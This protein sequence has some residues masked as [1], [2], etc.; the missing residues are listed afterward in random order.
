MH[1]I[2]SRGYQV[3][4]VANRNRNRN[5]KQA[6]Q[7]TS[8]ACNAAAASAHPK[9]LT[10]SLKRAF[11]NRQHK[12]PALLVSICPAVLVGFVTLVLVFAGVRFFLRVYLRPSLLNVWVYL[13]SSLCT[14]QMLAVGREIERDD[15]LFT[16]ALLCIPDPCEF[17]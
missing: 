6:T 9:P 1:A 8:S 3:V 10:Q 16:T 11:A 17:R 2:H 5:R 13:R 14:Y 15:I 4:C 12:Q 7:T